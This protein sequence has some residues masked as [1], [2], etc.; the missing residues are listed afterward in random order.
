MWNDVDVHRAT[1]GISSRNLT[2]ML[3]QIDLYPPKGRAVRELYGSVGEPPAAPQELSSSNL[4]FLDDDTLVEAFFN[5][6]KYP[7]PTIMVVLEHSAGP[8]KGSPGP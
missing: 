7:L 3:T 1:V 6:A 5:A 8:R 4:I 2:S